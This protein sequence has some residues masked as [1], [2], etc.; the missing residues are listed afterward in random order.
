MSN[1]VDE[2]TLSEEPESL[3]ASFHRVQS[4]IPIEQEVEAIPPEMRV[5]EALK[6]MQQKRYSQL[7]VVAGDAVLGVFS[8]RSFSTKA[9]AKQRS[10][11]DPLGDLPVE[12]FL[13]E[14]E[15][16][17]PTED[18]NRVLKYLDQDDAFFVGHRDGIEGMVTTIDMF[19]YFRAIANPFILIAEIEQS[20]RLII[21]TCINGDKLSQAIENSLSSAYKDGKHPTD[22]SEMTFDNFVQIICNSDNWQHF[23]EMFGR[24]PQTRKRTENRLRQT[25][26]WRN[27]VFHFRRRLQDWELETLAETR[28][29]LHLRGRAFEGRRRH[30]QKSILPES[31]QDQPAGDDFKRLLTRRHLPD[32]QRQLY[33]ALYHAGEDGLSRDELVELM[34]RRDRTELGGVIGSLGTRVNYTPGY[35]KTYKPG[36]EMAIVFRKTMDGTRLSLAP[37]L[38]AA[39]EELGPAWLGEQPNPS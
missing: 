6:L 11:R 13:E 5:S 33:R 1:T 15:Y 35:G 29:W 32:G 3:I 17:H 4:L 27:I 23:E 38:R 2:L 39:L 28:E 24:Q 8:Y 16:V 25:G 7:P 20:L 19:E 21:Q 34:G 9:I 12:E 30:T 10:A 36:V 22:L 37:G 26:Q 31:K 18:W 14:F